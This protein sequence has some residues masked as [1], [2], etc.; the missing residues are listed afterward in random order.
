MR[1]VDGGCD[2]ERKILFIL[3]EKSYFTAMSETE[4]TEIEGAGKFS[5]FAGCLM[6][7]IVGLM[8]AGVIVYSW[9]SY[10]QVKSTV[11]GFTQEVAQEVPLI[12]VSSME[13]AQKSLDEELKA[14]RVSVESNELAELSLTAEELNVAIASYEI[15]APNREK[16]FISG[17]SDKGVEATISYP[18]NAAAFSDNRR[19]LNGRVTMMPEINGGALFPV[20]KQ[21][22]TPSGVDIPDRFKEFITETMLHPIRNHEEL[23]VLMKRISS[24][25]IKG[26]SIVILAEPGFVAAGE[27]PDDTQPILNRFM[28]GF[29]IVAVVFLFIVSLI[30]FVSRRKASSTI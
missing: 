19:H 29:A 16:I 4:S 9:W 22:T 20:V 15:L 24:V 2:K 26:E 8:V 18:V 6:M 25:S 30:I 3:Y 10:G 17:I 23:G 21:V 13:A 12:D 14:F 11:E 5:P 27:L 1:R 28:K 7:L